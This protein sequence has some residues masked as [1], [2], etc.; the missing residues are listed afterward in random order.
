MNRVVVVMALVCSTDGVGAEP[1]NGM[2][3]SVPS[4]LTLYTSLPPGEIAEV[5]GP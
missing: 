2:P 1:P 5:S 3:F 4:Q